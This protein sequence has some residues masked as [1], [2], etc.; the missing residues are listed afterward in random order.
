MSK[1]KNNYLIPLIVM[2]ALMFM[3]GFITTMNN[4]LIEFLQK[5]FKLGE[6]E[7]QYVNTAF[8]G[9]YILSIPAGMVIKK[10]GYKGGLIGGLMFIAAGFFLC[11]PGVANGYYMFLACMFLV[12]TGIVLLQVALNPYIIALGEPDT[13]SRRLTIAASLNS[14]ATTIAPIFVSTL[15]MS[16]IKGSDATAMQI[17]FLGIGLLTAI[18]VVTLVPMKLPSIKEEVS[19]STMEV[20]E[21]SSPWA[22]KNLIFGTIAIF[23]YMGIEIGIPSFFKDF[24]GI[25][26]DQTSSFSLLGFSFVISGTKLLSFYWGGLMVGRILGIGILKKFRS[27]QVLAFN[28]VASAILLVLAMMSTGEARVWFFLATGLF[29]SV[30]WPCIF[31]LAIKDLG[32]HAKVASGIICTA[33][34]GGALLPPMMAKIGEMSTLMVGVSCI[35]F[36]YAYEIFFA[37]KG[38]KMR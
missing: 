29:H 25:S 28:S 8:F 37:V 1:S 30:M 15:I 14:L 19:T 3:V 20:V 16:N 17:P 35:L 22:Y 26:K 24:T 21:K 38:S 13:S 10:L 23:F 11:Y 12:A 5:A 31:D 27:K 7:K 33:V 6:V 9:A 32:S 4:S 36:Y 18:L 2:C 34:I